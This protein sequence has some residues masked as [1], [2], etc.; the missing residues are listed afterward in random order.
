MIAGASDLQVQLSIFW[1]NN[2]IGKLAQLLVSAAQKAD[3]QTAAVHIYWS[4]L[5][6]KLTGRQLPCMYIHDAQ[7]C[8]PRRCSWFGVFNP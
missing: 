6:K 1:G 4:Q 3:R 8:E 2:I 5:L 7:A